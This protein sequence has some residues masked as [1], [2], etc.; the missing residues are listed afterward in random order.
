MWT[1]KLCETSAAVPTGDDARPARILLAPGTLTLGRTPVDVIL[2]SPHISRQHATITVDAGGSATLAD[3]SSNGCTIHRNG[4]LLRKLKQG[5]QPLQDGDQIQFGLGH[6]I[7]EDGI[8]YKYVLRWEDGPQAAT[9]AAPHAVIS[10]PADPLPPT[11]TPAPQTRAKAAAFKKATRTARML[12]TP[13]TASEPS[14]AT[15][16]E[17]E[18][19]TQPQSSSLRLF[20]DDETPAAPPADAMEVDTTHTLEP[21]VVPP[22][23]STVAGR[24]S[25]C[26]GGGREED[27]AEGLE[28]VHLFDQASKQVV[29]PGAFA[30]GG[31]VALPQPVLGVRGTDAPI[32]SPELCLRLAFHVPVRCTGRA[33]ITRFATRALHA[34]LHCSRNRRQAAVARCE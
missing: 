32:S 3:S 4:A 30:A 23:K 34:P 31:D 25:K 16:I 19:D 20:H 9:N 22:H 6:A 21:I 29:A 11:A 8:E 15:Q 12:T 14:V 13:L 26:R 5:Q 24:L 28:L 1:L 2:P 33:L 17:P 27:D 18:M 10:N 7:A